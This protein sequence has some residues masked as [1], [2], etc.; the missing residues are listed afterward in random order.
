MYRVLYN[1]L[2]AGNK[3]YKYLNRLEKRLK[4]E[5]AEYSV[6][7]ILSLQGDVLEY[8]KT[9]NPNDIIIIV[10]GD[11]TV[12]RIINSISNIYFPNRVFLY[13]A[14]NGNDYCRGHKGNYFE[15]TNE[16]KDLPKLHINGQ[17]RV[18]IN[19]VGMG[20]DAE[21]C[22]EIEKVR[23]VNKKPSYFKTAKKGFKTFKPFELDIKIDDMEYSFKDVWFFV[24]MNGK[25]IGGG[26]KIAPKAIR[27]D[28]YLDVYVI[29]KMKKRKLLLCFP[30]IFFGKHLWFKK[31]GIEEFRAKKIDARA[32]GYNTLQLDGEVIHNVEEISVER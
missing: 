10:G 28:E 20:I 11:G 18:F 23:V 15:I 2:S 22:D 7:N 14:G 24:I 3:C 29:H 8:T 31:S 16:I 17:E 6:I 1:P 19:G 25:Y 9:L 13:K 5:K 27:E 12:H 21:V 4:K 32:N 26:M 30:F